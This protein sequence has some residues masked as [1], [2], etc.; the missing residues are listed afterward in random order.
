MVN[1]ARWIEA[2]ADLVRDKKLEGISDIRD[3][4]D[5]TGMRVVFEL[6]RDTVAQ[7]TLNQ[8]WSNTAMESS[9]G[10][11]ILAI[12]DGEPKIC[13][14]KDVLVAFVDHRREVVT[15]RTLFE[16]RQAEEKFHL[17]LGLLAAIDNIDRVIEIIR[18]AKD[19]EEAHVNLCAERFPQL[20]NLARLVEAADAQITQSLAQGWVQLTDKQAKA[21]LELRLQSP[22]RPR[23]REAAR[24]STASCGP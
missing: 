22:D 3:E 10:I 7:V 4:S 11:N 6:K 16:L 8:L 17:L 20:G 13:S 21:I 9:F 2:T 18:A 1:K 19:P 5:R 23:A 24:P 12:A 14:I 15:R